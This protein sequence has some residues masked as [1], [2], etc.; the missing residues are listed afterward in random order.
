VQRSDRLPSLDGLRGVAAIAVVFEHALLIFPTIW[1][2]FEARRVGHEALPLYVKVLTFTPLHLIWAGGEA[3]AIFFVLSG[4][5]LSLPFW[6]GRQASLPHYVVQRLIRL[7]PV[8]LM[9][10]GLPL[11]LFHAPGLSAPNGTSEW[12]QHYWKAPPDG[13]A[14]LRGLLF[15]NS[16][17]LD[18]NAPLWTL[19]HEFRISLLLPLL[20][21]LVRR[22]PRASMLAAILL[23]LGA[24]VALTKHLVGGDFANLTETVAQLWYFIAGGLIAR[25]WAEILGEVRSLARWQLTT[26][27]FVAVLLLLLQWLGP[28]P[29]AVSYLSNG[30]GA[31]G[32]V[33]LAGASLPVRRLLELRPCQFAGRLSYSLYALHFPVLFASVLLLGNSLGLP[34]AIVIGLVLGLLTATAVN[35]LIEAPLMAAGRELARRLRPISSRNVKPAVG[36]V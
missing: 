3:V 30:F 23:S 2:A 22:W 5:V 19:I 9:A 32:A 36:G 24:K 31:V 25:Y 27:I 1:L 15:T 20:L 26:G 6:S 34:A 13:Q 17:L 10:I 4:L 11:L 35:Y 14:I 7:Y 18:L 8:Y 21:P 29:S 33:I 28:V 16:N 12:F